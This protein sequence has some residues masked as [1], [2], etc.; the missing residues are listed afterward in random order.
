M[1]L[2]T[3]VVTAGDLVKVL[4]NP[5]DPVWRPGRGTVLSSF[6][7]GT[8]VAQRALLEGRARPWRS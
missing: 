4:S 1:A 7:H 8:T 5:A 2:F 6:A 3:D